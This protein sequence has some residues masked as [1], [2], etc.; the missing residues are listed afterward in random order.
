MLRAEKN[1][2]SQIGQNEPEYDEQSKD[3]MMRDNL[4]SHTSS[5]LNILIPFPSPKGRKPVYEVHRL[6]AFPSNN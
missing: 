5:H 6:I 1:E 2:Y 4:L 3:D